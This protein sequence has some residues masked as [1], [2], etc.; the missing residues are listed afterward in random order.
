LSR[1]AVIVT[2][3]LSGELHAVHL[4]RAIA[5]SLQMEFSGMGS[6]RLSD[7]GV[8]LVHD[9]RDISL[10]GLSEVFFRAG[11]IWKAYVSLTRHLRETK[12]DLLI[13]VDFPGFNLRIARVAKR[14]GVPTVYFIPPQIWAWRKN[15]MKQ[16]KSWIDL[17]LCILPFEE[18]LYREHHVP[19]RYIGHP[20]LHIVRPRYTKEA[21]RSMFAIR[22]GAPV[23]T[24]MPGSRQNEARRHIPVLTD[25]VR[26]LQGKLGRLTVLLPVADT[27]DEAFFVP[28]IREL[29]GVIPIK[30]LPYDC[31]AHSDAAVIA[32]GS[33]TLEAA[34]LGVPSVVLYKISNLSYLIARM[35]VHVSHISLPNI[36]A[37][38]E[39]FPE[40]V[41]SL[42]AERIANTIVSMVN[43][44]KSALQKEM[45][46]VRK[47][48]ATPDHDPYR[49][50]C[51]E[52]LQF[53]ERRYGPLP[54][55]P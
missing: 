7:A 55:T 8:K 39:I 18:A 21:F 51:T 44:D 9:Y 37:G 4:V 26:H 41:Q 38:R 35:V 47:K 30:G 40:F 10:T 29:D 3:E 34:I 16:I 12:P 20:F 52:I 46:E 28:F 2:G 6:T 49:V 54:E 15:R 1:K 22:E 24:I 32:S 36:I 33:A 45:E 23:I 48:L 13:L 11:H 53:L 31:L 17:V 50:A 5:E 27:M 25:I 42:D 14:L 19:A 43:T